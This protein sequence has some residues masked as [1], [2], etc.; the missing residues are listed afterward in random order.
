MDIL[1]VIGITSIISVIVS[2]I[3]DLMK[4]RH[5]LKFEKITSEKESRYRSILVFMMVVL[6][7]DNLRHV[8]TEYKPNSN[9]DV[10]AYYLDELRIH[11]K[12]S[13]LYA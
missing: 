3:F 6:D 12:F 10:K 1:E 13:R 8:S 5:Y 7:E 11:L 4:N 2:Y 9:Q